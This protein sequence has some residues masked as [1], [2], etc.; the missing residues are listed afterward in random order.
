MQ[1]TWDQP[2]FQEC[3]QARERQIYETGPPKGHNLR[4]DL[5]YDL[6]QSLHVR[7]KGTEVCD[8]HSFCDLNFTRFAPF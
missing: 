7:M 1:T 5:R 3:M 2:I 6:D 8:L 4:A